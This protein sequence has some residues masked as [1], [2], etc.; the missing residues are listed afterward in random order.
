MP[1]N[2]EQPKPKTPMEFLAEIPGA[3]TANEVD[4]WRMSVPGG[5]M[6]VFTPDSGKRVFVLR[7]LSGLEMEAISKSIPQNASN[8][9]LEMQIHCCVKAILWTNVTRDGQV[10][11]MFFR[12][13]PA[14][15]ASSMFGLVSRLSDFIDPESLEMM[16][17]EL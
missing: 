11:E 5:K 14:G 10:D 2:T 1:E 8:A 9:E 6:R 17:A 7:A 15:L 16:S 4:A 3:P 13:S 12:K